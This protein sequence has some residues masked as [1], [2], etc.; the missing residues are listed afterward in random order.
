MVGPPPVPPSGR[1]CVACAAPL[2]PWGRKA[3][4]DL[5]RCGGCGLI[6]LARLPDPG[7][8]VATYGETLFEAPGRADYYHRDTRTLAAN[9][10]RKWREV[11]ALEPRGGR[12]LD[13]GTAFGFFPAHAPRGW[14]VDACELSAHAARRARELHGIPVAQGDFLTLAFEPGAYDVVTLWDCLEHLPDPAATLTKVG[15]LLRPGGAVLLTT[16]D[17]GSRLA[18]LAGRRWRLIK[19]SQ[20]LYCFTACSLAHLLRAAGLGPVRLERETRAFNLSYLVA[21][22]R[23]GSL[24]LLG[25]AVRLLARGLP[26]RLDLRLGDILLLAARTPP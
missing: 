20:H 6:T 21:T 11:A 2:H 8:L 23:A 10:L 17:A 9:A 4:V 7:E 26:W 14:R 16:G 18:R 1:P 13:V 25:P 15:R 22:S 5:L 3:G 19:P 24:P 12:L